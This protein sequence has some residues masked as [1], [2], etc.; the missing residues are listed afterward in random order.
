[1]VLLLS[2]IRVRTQNLLKQH[3]ALR[4]CTVSVPAPKLTIKSRDHSQRGPGGSGRSC[5]YQ[6]P[7]ALPRVSWHSKQEEEYLAQSVFIP[8]QKHFCFKCSYI[9]YPPIWWFWTW[10]SSIHRSCWP[11]GKYGSHLFCCHVSSWPLAK[12]RRVAWRA[13]SSD[14]SGGAVAPRR[15]YYS[16]TSSVGH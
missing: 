3:I 9:F 2:L 14:S 8:G 6:E 12:E 5:P 15:N 1:V 10:T 11:K 7:C 4:T 16:K 13:K